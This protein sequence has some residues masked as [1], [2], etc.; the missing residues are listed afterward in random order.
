MKIRIH[1]TEQSRKSH[2]ALLAHAEYAAA[3]IRAKQA[4]DV[5]LMLQR[6]RKISRPL[7]YRLNPDHTVTPLTDLTEDVSPANL[8]EFTEAFRFENRRVA[9]TEFEDGSLISTVFLCIDHNHGDG[10][11]ILFETMA[12]SGATHR[13]E[14]LGRDVREELETRR[15]CTWDEAVAGHEAM[16]RARRQILDHLKRMTPDA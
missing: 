16:V 1:A 2:A 6:L 14:I 3:I 11:P 7:N 13:N 9:S 5:K 4:A 12:F 15:Y 8:A 10:P